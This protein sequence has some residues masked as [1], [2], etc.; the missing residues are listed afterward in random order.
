MTNDIVLVNGQEGFIDLEIVDKI[1]ID[2]R[3][4]SLQRAN[5]IING[6]LSGHRRK[7]STILKHRFISLQ[8]S[9]NHITRE[10]GA[11][12][13][14][15]E[16]KKLTRWLN[17][18][19]KIHPGHRK[20]INKVRSR[21]TELKNMKR[22]SIYNFDKEVFETLT[23]KIPKRY[24]GEREE[25]FDLPWYGRDGM[26]ITV[27]LKW[28]SH[29]SIPYLEQQYQLRRIKLSEDEEYM[30]HAFKEAMR[31][32]DEKTTFTDYI[33]KW[34]RNLGKEVEMNQLEL[35]LKKVKRKRTMKNML[36]MKL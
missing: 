7:I 33:D 25:Q 29:K 6:T 23:K 5:S 34:A 17:A 22:Q 28:I 9:R 14:E 20:G 16:I 30:L 2:G 13:Y 24:K 1:K 35:K 10:Y 15:K 4:F 32:R 27:F 8:I 3:E 21:L 11:I 31:I 19:H 36:E 26:K 18:M 12:K